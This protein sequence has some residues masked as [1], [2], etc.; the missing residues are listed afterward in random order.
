MM[1]K[2]AQTKWCGSAWLKAVCACSDASPPF[3]IYTK[4]I[5]I[6]YSLI[7]IERTSERTATKKKIILC[8]KSSYRNSRNNIL[9]LNT[10][11]HSH[12]NK[13]RRSGKFALPILS[14]VDLAGKYSCSQII[15][16]NNTYTQHAIYYSQWGK[17][18]SNKTSRFTHNW[19]FFM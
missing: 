13:K 2:Q 19:T 3:G 10:F 4:K 8:V 11:T 9:F 15:N 14:L 18:W 7:K 16:A 17:R 12:I 6:R 1:L 5:T